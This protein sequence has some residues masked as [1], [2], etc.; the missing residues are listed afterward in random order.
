MRVLT[1]PRRR[2][3]L[4]GSLILA[5]S[6]A[7]LGTLVAAPVA[8]APVPAE[9]QFGNYSPVNVSKYRSL[10]YADD[11]RVFFVAGRWRCQI[12]R[13]GS[14]GCQGRPATAPPGITGVA[15]TND[16]Q[17][18]LWVPPGTT[19][20]FGSQAGFRAPVL[21]VGQRISVGTTVCARPRANVVSCATSNRAFILSP[22]W[23]KFYY[24]KGDNRH[25]S[26][27]APRYLPAQLR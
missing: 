13:P 9:L 24:P 15:I 10:R 26:N 3:T 11:G 16:L 14:V 19:Y 2:R 12:G 6:A 22:A 18:P 25:S 7:L 5:A 23:H 8:A 1:T 21:N 27:P 4:L 20:R 17:G